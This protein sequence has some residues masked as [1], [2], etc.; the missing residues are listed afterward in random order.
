M[1]DVYD[2][3][4]L[5]SIRNQDGVWINTQVFREEA[6]HFEKYGYYCADPWGSPGWFEY[7]EEQTKRCKEGYEV[8]G[9]KITGNHYAYLNFYPIL[10]LDMKAMLAGEEVS[11]KIQAMPDFWDGDYNFWWSQEIAFKGINKAAP[12]GYDFGKF[13]SMSVFDKIE[14]QKGFRDRL[15]LEVGIDEKYFVG[16]HHM[17]V[18]KS[19]R[20]GYSF[21]NAAL[22]ANTYNH[23]RKSQ[24]IV[25][26]FLKEYLYPTGLMGM[27]NAYIAHTDEHTA[28]RKSRDYVDK[29]SHKKASYKETINGLGI[30]KGYQSEI[31]ALTFKDNA[32]ASRGKSAMFVLFEEAGKFPNLR[33]S[34]MAT[35]PAL[36][37]GSVTT[38]QMI[39][40]G[41]GGDMEKGTVDFANMFY[42]PGAYKLMAFKNIWDKDAGDSKC[43]FFHPVYW[44]MEGYYDDQGNSDREGATEYEL[45]RRKEIMAESSD[46]KAVNDHAQEFPVMPSEAFLMVSNNDFPIVELRNRLNLVVR[47]KLQTIKGQAVELYMEGDDVKVKPDL[48]GKLEPIFHMNPKTKNIKSCPVIYEYPVD[49]APRGLYKIG[50]DPYRQDEGTSLASV[51]VYKGNNKFSYTR[52]T[53]VA[54]YTGRPKTTDECN[55]IVL[56]LAILYN[57]EVMYENEVPEV[58]SYFANK[59]KLQYLAAQPDGVISKNI[60]NSRVNRVYGIHMNVKLK[61]AGEKYIKRWLLE[62]R[63]IDEE[64]NVILNLDTIC[65]IGLLEELIAYNRKGNFDRVMSFMTLMFALEEEGDKEF[66][67]D[68]EDNIAKDILS[69]GKGLF[70]RRNSLY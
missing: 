70:K 37:A 13:S 39:I 33:A 67:K 14:E 68:D 17:I 65:S 50:Y 3:G 21:K 24:C 36:E 25:G 49:N 42:N 9:V 15:Q 69:F 56:M 54:E 22:L 66:K 47:E 11:N 7:W 57:A 27:V 2:N 34:Y 12:I 62:E 44:N 40:F 43:G 46:S 31:F 28:W 59:K 1:A 63:D 38:G 29:I 60:K 8:G 5:N 55:R 30:E 64:G 20:K 6:N 58:K 16:G 41:T 48:Q 61:D 4:K 18:G 23:Y 10:K 51:I 35:K 52:D 26:A 53:I 32:D 45:G 19:R